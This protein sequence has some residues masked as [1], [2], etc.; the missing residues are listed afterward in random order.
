MPKLIQ[1]ITAEVLDSFVGEVRLIKPL[2]GQI[3][4][5]DYINLNGLICYL[6]NLTEVQFTQALI[7]PNN[8][9]L[10]RTN[11]TQEYILEISY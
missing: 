9:G 4:Q 11:N 6:Q 2:S 8:F 1:N 3:Q 7:K 5:E 10:K